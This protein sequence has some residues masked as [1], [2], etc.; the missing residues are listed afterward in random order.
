M[1]IHR[2]QFVVGPYPINSVPGWVTTYIPGTGY[3]CHCPELRVASA[4]DAD[5]TFWYLLGLVVQTDINKLEP[6]DAIATATSN[7]IQ[8]LYQSW[9]GRWVLIGDGKLHID[10]AGLLGC[11]YSLKEATD[12]T[13]ELWVSSSASLLS[14]LL[15]IDTIAYL[16]EP[17]SKGI[18]WY[19]GP[20]SR[21][22]SIWRLLPSQILGLATGDLLARRLVHEISK[23]LS[24]DE[25]LD[26]IQEH[27][28]TTLKQASKQTNNL[29]LSLTGGYDSR[30]LL[31][32]ARYAGISAK[33]YTVGCK[34]IDYADLIIPPK[35]AKAAGFN[36][37]FYWNGSFKQ[38]L[39]ALCDQHTGGHCI[40]RTRDWIS[41]ESFNW[42]QKG[43]L[44]LSGGCFE[45]GRCHYW[46]RFPESS[47]PGAEVI[48]NGLSRESFHPSLISTIEEWINWVIRTPHKDLDWR[49]R[50]YLE[51]R[52]AGWMSSN[53]QAIDL[54]DAEIFHPVN[55][56]FYFSHILQIPEEKRCVSQHHVDLINRMAPELLEFPFNP[57]PIHK[58]LLKKIKSLLTNNTLV[59]NRP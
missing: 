12:G 29:W 58:S 20:Q 15:R 53:V 49:D 44:V 10:S 11:F 24:Y 51:L 32:T 37:S 1:H 3:L 22:K 31:A 36:H 19:P 13:K 5:G 9:A 28:V 47:L 14:D 27:L 2:R 4:K 30:V 34:S 6:I 25:L 40:T 35:L 23:T 8:D 38:D 50:L 46:Q 59:A 17:D 7:T 33:T 18:D 26:R 56:H 52:L 21:F 41:R 48:L 42:F 57:S 43:D 55:S 16:I 45:M 39:A 54:I